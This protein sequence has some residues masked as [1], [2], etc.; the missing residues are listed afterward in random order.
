MLRLKELISQSNVELND[1]KIHCAT[2]S[3]WLPLDAFFDGRFEEWQEHQNKR[4]FQCEKVVSLIHLRGTEWL[5]AGVWAVLGS[6]PR[7]T[8]GKTWFQYSTKEVTGLE[9]LVGHAVIKFDK[10]FRASYLKGPKYIDQLEVIEL[11]R[12]RMSIG[13]FPGFSKIRLS[14]SRLRVVFRQDVDTWR[15]A[16]SSV[17]GIYVIADTKTGSLYV[18]SAYGDGG[19]WGRWSAYASTGHGGNKE[20]RRLLRE[21]GAEYASNF[22]Y[23]ILEICDLMMTKEQIIERESHWKDCLLSRQF[24]YNEN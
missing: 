7:K 6:K 15:S 19:I 14:Y 3:E 18:G 24:G 16:L 21:N 9:H 2:G 8:K 13:D 11:R 10:N 4:N 20:L 12:E 23:T 17:S 22:Q 1:F 5:F